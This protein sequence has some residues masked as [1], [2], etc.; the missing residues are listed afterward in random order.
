MATINVLIAVDGAALAAKIADKSLSPGSI[1]SPTSLG[2][3]ANGT[4]LRL[5][6]M[7]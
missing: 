3:Y 2:S 6:C 1:G 4:D 7:K 5:N